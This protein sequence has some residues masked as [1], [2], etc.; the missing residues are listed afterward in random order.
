MHNFDDRIIDELP[1][2]EIEEEEPPPPPPPM[3]TESELEAAKNSAFQEGHAQGVKETQDSRAQSLAN[4]MQQLADDA[5]A[6]FTAEKTREERFEQE[7]ISLCHAI[8]SKAF[9]AFQDQFGLETLKEQLAQVLAA[10]NNQKNIQ[11]RVSSDFASG[12][13]AFMN[14]LQQ[15]NSDLNFVVKADETLENGAF[16]IGWSD[17]GAVYDSPA[18]A[19]EILAN[20]E[21]MLAGK[22]VTSHNDSSEESNT[23]MADA[24]EDIPE[25][26]ETADSEDEINPIAEENND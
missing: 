15:Q 13:E 25:A 11:I 23:S 8:F 10:L 20:L 26:I 7:V 22:G 4:M 1:P 24:S 5:K 19:R 6:L 3:F 2:E 16:H 17:G 14:K 12:V 9:P 21:E 18:L